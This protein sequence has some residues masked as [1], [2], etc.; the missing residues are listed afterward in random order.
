MLSQKSPS[1][2]R[3]A[4]IGLGALII[5][6]SLFALASPAITYISIILILAIVLFFVGI[7][8][9]L[10]GIFSPGKSRWANIGLG[11]LVLIFAGL[12]ISYPATT[13]LIIII[14]IAVAFLI[15]GIARIIEGFSGK[16]SGASRAFL[17]GVGALA[18]ALSI[19]VLVSPFFGAALAGI[20]IAVGL[21]I[22]GI[23][24]VVAGFRGR[25]VSVPGTAVN[26]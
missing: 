22:T 15:N 7:E 8:E 13:A 6:L 21:L 5:V 1:W 16:H 4:Q 17:V 24:M 18:I 14:F 19:A 12:A 3:A 25:K 11:V 26:R 20:V 10:V 23:Q 9:I 2:L